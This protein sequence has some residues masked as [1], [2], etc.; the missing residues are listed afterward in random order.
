MT[1]PLT[2]E[3]FLA[4]DGPLARR[5]TGFEL[6]PQQLRMA[7]RIGETMAA[8][9][10]LMVEAGTGVGKSFAYLLPAIR[11]IVEQRE[12]VIVCTHTVALQ[13][14]LVE[15]DVPLLQALVGDF[16]VVLVKGRG[17]YVSLRRLQRACDA[18]GQLF[19]EEES[20]HALEGLREWAA[21]TRDGSRSSLPQ[22]PPPAVWAAV[23]SDADNC[24]GKRCPTYE[25]CFFQAA[26]RRLEHADLLICNHSIFFADLALKAQE[27]GFLPPVQ[28]LIFDE[29]HTLEDVAAEH[30]G[31]RLTE[32]QL[33]FLLRS[34]FDE[35]TRRG[36]LATL[37]L[38]PSDVDLVD[39]AVDA[40][41]EC[42]LEGSRFFDD[43]W[44]LGASAGE[45]LRRLA[46]GAV[47][48]APLGK[49]LVR[50]RE[51]LGYLRERV[52]GEGEKSEV[53]SAMLRTGQLAGAAEV[54]IE[55]RLGGCVYWTELAGDGSRGGRRGRSSTRQRVALCAAPVEVGPIL[56]EQLFAKGSSVVLTSATLATGP[57]DF[58][59]ALARLGC[60]AA[61]TLQLGSP[62][63][64]ARQVML[65][66]DADLPDPGE[67]SFIQAVIPRILE[68]IVATD[69]GAFVLFTSFAMLEE[70][71]SRLR[72]PLL[73]RGHPVLVHG[74][75]ME[76]TAMVNRFRESERSV[77]FGTASFWQG[78]DV[79]GR[80]LR[81]VIIVRL[82]FEVP[83]RP[84][85][86]A[87]CEAIEARGGS[88]FS[89]ESLPK[90]IIR[91]R[92]GFGRLIRSSADSGRVVV[93]DRRIV[94]KG[95]G[96][97]FLASLPEGVVVDV[98]RP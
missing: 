24:L 7:E 49:A 73:D 23:Q 47:D 17:Q 26:R 13:E 43:L 42:R 66:L 12:R 34:L 53:G 21:G 40:L 15:K 22:I 30:F 81:N 38:P 80:A 54:L 39:H 55:Q 94:T 74:E 88:A 31:G 27:R 75:S 5:L 72:Q 62:F 78:V 44:R 52:S 84:L 58:T 48:H 20:S 8:R 29:A 91:F 64:F 86:Q 79:R 61:A 85:V 83:D 41:R 14:Q 95:Y 6:R 46:A 92:Q 76:R 18:S 90:A 60:D 63:D 87:R 11:R 82:P 70:V 19:P 57:G 35:R 3:S 25:Q 2:F 50:L 98:R 28:H 33:E 77:L 56:R 65:H 32:G 51:L 89:E 67:R 9:G 97:K 1:A 71:V 68:H 37:K 45:P 16:S 4:P 93:L 96:R 36:L 10:H 69:G 59:H